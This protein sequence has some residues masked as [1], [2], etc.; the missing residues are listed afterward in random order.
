ME[1]IHI[2]DKTNFIGCWNL[3][4]EKLCNN[5][6]NLFEQNKQSHVK[7]VLGKQGKLIK[8]VKNQ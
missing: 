7:G 4:D 1:R 6:I 2:S 5:I 8:V 3:K